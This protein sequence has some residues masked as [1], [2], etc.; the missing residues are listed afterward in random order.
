MVVAVKRKR[1]Q[2]EYERREALKRRIKERQWWVCPYLKGRE[3]FGA[4]HISMPQ[5]E[6]FEIK[7]YVNFVRMSPA[8]FN[9][10]LEMCRP[11]LEKK[12]TNCREPHPPGL[13]LA[14][15]LRFLAT[16]NSYVSLMYLFRVR[17]NTISKFVPYVC[18]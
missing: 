5:F 17:T 18:Q 4:Y 3:E 14:V 1:L 16:G 13:K 15:T 9:E 2:E 6:E 8:L 12:K 10:L 11:Y 7:K